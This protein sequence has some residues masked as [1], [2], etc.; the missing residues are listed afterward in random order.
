MRPVREVVFAQYT[1]GLKTLS[2]FKVFVKPYMLSVLPAGSLPAP[3][4]TR[5]STTTQGAQLA[6]LQVPSIQIVSSLSTRIVQTISFPFGTAPGGKDPVAP[7]VARVLT[8]SPSAKAPL[9]ATTTPVDKTLA[10]SEGSIIWTFPLESWGLQIDEL[11]DAG[12]YAEALA[13]LDQLDVTSLPDKV[14]MST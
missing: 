10:T 4:S 14:R 7:V 1:S 9:F 8:P 2:I 12:K 3:P 6:M 5:P 11:V 13:L